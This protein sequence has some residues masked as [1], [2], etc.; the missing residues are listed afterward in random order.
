MYNLHNKLEITSTSNWNEGG[1]HAV[2]VTGIN[3]K[4]FIVSS[5]GNKYLIKYDDLKVGNFNLVATE[6]GG[7]KNAKIN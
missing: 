2:F 6:I 3:K 1:G 5:W 7:I 4:G